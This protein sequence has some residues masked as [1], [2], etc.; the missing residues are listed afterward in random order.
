M[1]ADPAGIAPLAQQS[2]SITPTRSIYRLAGDGVGVTMTF[3]TPALPANIDVLSRPVTYIS[4]DVKSTDGKPHKVKVY[5]DASG[6]ISADD[7]KLS[8]SY[9][10]IGKSKEV[11][12]V[13]TVDQPV[14]KKSGD[15]RRIDWG[16]LYLTA[17]SK[18]VPNSVSISKN[19]LGSF[20]RNG[21]LGR[22]E[23][24]ADEPA[25]LGRTVSLAFDLGTITKKPVAAT[26]LLAYD[27][28][29]SI[30]YFGQN[31]RPYWRRNGLDA[32]G[33]IQKS[34]QQYKSLLSQAEKFDHDFTADLV[35]V[36]GTKYAEICALAFRQTF[37]GNK[38]AADKNGQPLL[39]PKE[40]SS[41]GCIGTVDV[42]F[43]MAPQFLLFGPSLTKAM[44]VSNLDYAQSKRWRWPFAPHDIGT[45]P[46]ANGQVYGGGERTIDNQ[47]PVEETGNMLILTAALARMEGNA[48]FA[49]KY[50]PT[51]TKWA[52]FLKDKGFDPENQLSTDDFLGH[53]AHNTN[54]SIKATLGLASYAVLSE[55][56]G[57]PETAKT[58]RNT[59]RSFAK[60]W[61]KEA[62]DGDH[63]RLA[64][65]Q[66]GSWSQKY[67]LVWDKILGLN[68]YPD[69]VAKVETA[70]YRSKMN[71]YGVA[72]DSRQ[73]GKMAKVDWSLWTACLSGNRSDFEQIM[74]PVWRYINETPNRVAMCD[75]YD[76]TNGRYVMF[77]ARPVVGG[78]FLKAL[79]DKAV[80]KKWASKD[81]TK[82]AGWAP[83]PT[84]PV[85]KE[86]VPTALSAKITWQYTTEKPIGDW[87][88][89]SYKANGWSIGLGGFGTSG[90]PGVNVRTEWK[91][92][93]IWLRREFEVK[94]PKGKIALKLY[95]DEDA[96]VYLNGK[97][98]TKE[99]GY[100]TTYNLIP[101]V[102][103]KR[104]LLRDGK[105]TIAIHCRQTSGGQG[106]DAGFV[107]IVK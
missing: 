17:A 80:W 4:W 70:F 75:N 26:S 94:V 106:V 54:L 104:E 21:T 28:Q 56:I 67:N 49:K 42:I 41:N 50:W 86:F 3:F 62:W 72:L 58:Y 40:N 84:P 83:L 91:T 2:L 96:E 68:I 73:G 22:S 81:V 66:A 30:Q 89:S 37:A 82:A 64:F 5:L 97:L 85:T 27:D 74:N 90:T 18:N 51:L 6:E 99:S 61:V 1:G 107:L 14:L 44:I 33:L 95:H 55:M 45:Y 105:N 77:H 35:K 38:I 87:M 39:F 29:F 31:L 7:P 32:N 16:Y 23:V 47:M 98:I 63:Y 43:P 79:Y 46:L 48:D 52:E 8:V 24:S 15:D 10:L 20:N 57:H 53:L 88:S 9:R 103:K 36:G 101:L 19:S 13:G 76:T 69:S 78:V 34:I 25:I 100:V 11:A 71:P 92:S 65:D 12:K 93:D 60:R 59:A 102:G